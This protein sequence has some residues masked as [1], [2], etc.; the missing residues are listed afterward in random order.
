MTD[1]GMTLCHQGAVFEIRALIGDRKGGARDVLLSWL[2]PP[3]PQLPLNCHCTNCSRMGGDG[4]QQAR[5]EEQ[6]QQPSN[7]K[8]TRFQPS[9][10]PTKTGKITNSL[11]RLLG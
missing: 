5:G 4:L 2:P 8:P 3:G 10:A 11:S 6:G 9:T 1:S 7:T